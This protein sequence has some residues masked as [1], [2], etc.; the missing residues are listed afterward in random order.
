[1]K[2]FRNL[3]A[4]YMPAAMVLSGEHEASQREMVEAKRGQRGTRAS[5]PLAAFSPSIRSADAQLQQGL[6][7]H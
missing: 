2:R 1:M 7:R 4:I 6:G 5:T 3:Q